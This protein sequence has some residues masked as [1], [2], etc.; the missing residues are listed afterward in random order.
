MPRG[1][2]GHHTDE[3]EMTEGDEVTFS[4]TW[5]RSWRDIPEPLGFD[6]RI[7]ATTDAQRE[8]SARSPD[9]VP[10]ADMVR[11]SL[12]TLL[13]MTHAETGGIVAAPTTSLPED[14][15]GERNWDYRFC[16]L[17]DAALTLESLLGAGYDDEAVGLATVAPARR[18]RR[19]RR[20]ADH[21]HRRR[22]VDSCP[23]SSSRTSRAMRQ[24]PPSASATAR[25][26]SGRTDV[27]G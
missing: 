4:T 1:T 19:P 12:L 5:V 14:F 23:S 2:D 3:F 7:A 9:D 8:W 26:P 15:G 6:E 21:V 18:R 25:S 24:P 27:L 10:H 22:R 17:R 11:R 13:L 20:P 16:W